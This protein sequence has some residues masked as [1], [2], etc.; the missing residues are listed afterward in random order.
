LLNPTINAIKILPDN[1]PN[2]STVAPVP[3]IVAPAPVPTTVAP[4]PTS[5]RIDCGGISN[6]TAN[7][8]GTTQDTL[9]CSDR[10]FSGPPNSKGTYVVPVPEGQYTVKM[11]FA[12][13]FAGGPNQRVF[14]IYVQGSLVVAGLDI[15]DQVG[16]NTAYDIVTVVNVTSAQSSITIDL[17]S[18]IENAKINVVFNFEN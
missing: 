2:T 15:Y 11:M 13:I 4:V 1:F 17:V 3:T 9:Y 10:V 12:E 18:K 7:I 5:I 16:A 6:W 14:D 8:D